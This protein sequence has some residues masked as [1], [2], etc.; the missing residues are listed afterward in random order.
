MPNPSGAGFFGKLP[1]TGD[2]VQ[3]RLPASFV[4]V[5][6]R[7]FEQAVSASR[8][9]LGD[10]WPQAWRDAAVWRFVLA[11]GICGELAW[12]GVTGAAT[13]RVGRCFPMVIAAPLADEAAI[14]AALRN[15]AW[16][17]AAER[18]PF[19]ARKRCARF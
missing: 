13:D 17:A 3:R 11:P 8:A 19:R 1:G 12:A 2:F 18:A 15:D 9:R 10:D 14:A 7:H 5:W 4:N 16:F 6:D